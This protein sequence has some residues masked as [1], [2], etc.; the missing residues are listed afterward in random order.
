MNSRPLIGG[1][2]NRM[3]SVGMTGNVSVSYFFVY[4]T[5]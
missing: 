2:V 4:S 5:R 3:Y 1:I